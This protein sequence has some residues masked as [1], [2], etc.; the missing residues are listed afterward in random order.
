M[1]ALAVRLEEIHDERLAAVRGLPERTYVQS[2]TKHRREE[3]LRRYPDLKR[4]WEVEAEYRRVAELRR[5]TLST[6]EVSVRVLADY[7]APGG[8][9]LP[10]SKSA[11]QRIRDAQKVCAGCG[12]KGHTRCDVIPF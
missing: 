11:I 5:E 1:A 4:V 12:R 8:E 3:L 2:V 7:G 10:E 6:V 9:P